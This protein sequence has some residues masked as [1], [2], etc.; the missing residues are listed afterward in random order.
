[1]SLYLIQYAIV[2]KTPQYRDLSI[3]EPVTTFLQLHR[4]STNEYGDPK[5]FIYRPTDQGLQLYLHFYSIPLLHCCCCCF[6]CLLNDPTFS[7][8]TLEL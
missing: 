8:V 5:P 3:T 4:P 6:W 1:M 7:S 2:F